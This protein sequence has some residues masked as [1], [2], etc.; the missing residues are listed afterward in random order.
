MKC[1]LLLFVLLTASSAFA[2]QGIMHSL[3][4]ADRPTYDDDDE[5][6]VLSLVLSS[7]FGLQDESSNAKL[8]SRTN[9]VN[10]TLKLFLHNTQILIMKKI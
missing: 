4:L 5:L 3:Y 10:K 7:D 1:F 2:K 6:S 8:K 9:Q